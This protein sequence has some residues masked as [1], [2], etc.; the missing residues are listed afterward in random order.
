MQRVLKL[1][2][3]LLFTS[4]LLPMGRAA[5]NT[6]PS[7]VVPAGAP[8]SEFVDDPGNGKDP[9]FPKS[10]RRKVVVRTPDAAPPDPTVPD[11][12]RLQGISFAAGRKLAIINN[13]TLGEGEEFTLKI[14]GQPVKIQCIEIK[15][16]SVIVAVGGATKEIPL[17]ASLQ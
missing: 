13:Y 17:R 10:T 1:L 5:D 8:K 11:F 12:V 16:K 3:V 14:N 15:E 6:L 2:A 7:S 9:F 4:I